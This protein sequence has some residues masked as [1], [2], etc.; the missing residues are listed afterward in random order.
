MSRIG[1][2]LKALAEA[3][4]DCG[5]RPA[6]LLFPLFSA[7]ALSLA[8]SDFTMH[9]LAHPGRGDLWGTAS[10]VLHFVLVT[11]AAVFPFAALVASAP[12]ARKYVAR[13]VRSVV[14]AGWPLFVWSVFSI[15]AGV[16]LVWILGWA[17]SGLMPPY[18]WVPVV[19]TVL[20]LPL[21]FV[22][23]ALVFEDGTVLDRV[24]LALRAFRRLWLEAA[25]G[26]LVLACLAVGFD[27]LSHVWGSPSRHWESVHGCR[28][29]LAAHGCVQGTGFATQLLA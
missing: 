22:I 3:M 29:Y 20:A 27:S 14:A 23:P 25:V 11:L 15:G 19:V 7:L 13:G 2:A 18:V 17:L 21:M 24:K 10:A 8:S 4:A 9:L 16:A 12:H 6:V 1:I 26:V 28:W 5:R